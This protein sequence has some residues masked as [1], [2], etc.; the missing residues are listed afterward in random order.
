MNY[1]FIFTLGALALIRPLFS[2]LGLLEMI[3]K[4]AASQAV[5]FVITIVW[6]AAA[7][8]KDIDQPVKTLIG[9][10]LVYGMFAIVI[11]AVLSPIVTGDLQGPLTHSLGALSVLLT[12]AIWGLAAG[13]IA[14]G[15][16]KTKEEQK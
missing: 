1:T 11:S 4:P 16:Q 8:W 14:A 9:A 13:V 12:N 6:V 7:V 2:G 10:G 5:T 3:G 15:L